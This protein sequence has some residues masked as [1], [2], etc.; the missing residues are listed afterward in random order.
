MRIVEVDAAATHD[1]RRR[2]LR[3]HQPG[4]LVEEAR[5]HLLVGV[6]KGRVGHALSQPE[7][8]RLDHRHRSEP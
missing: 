8:R 6:E 2:V 4:L 7:R 1:L 5:P 3:S